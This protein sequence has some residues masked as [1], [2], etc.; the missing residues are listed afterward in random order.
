M[1]TRDARKLKTNDFRIFANYIYE[2][3]KIEQLYYD[4]KIITYNYLIKEIN[5]TKE[6]IINTIEYINLHIQG[7][8]KILREYD[9]EKYIIQKILNEYNYKEYMIFNEEELKK[10]INLCIDFIIKYLNTKWFWVS[11]FLKRI[12]ES[13]Q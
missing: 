12:L 6:D 3:D 8:Q 4:N 2:N 7:K 5:I 10:H 13:V 1:W 11:F 9:C